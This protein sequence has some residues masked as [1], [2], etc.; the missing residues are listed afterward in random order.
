[1]AQIASSFNPLTQII[2]FTAL[3]RILLAT[4]LNLGN[5]EV[6]YF[7]YAV[8]PD[9]NH[10]DHPPLVG[11]F[12]RLTTLNLT[13]ISDLSMRLPAIFGAAINT[14][15]IAKCT[16]R[17][18]N[19]RAGIFASILYNASIYTSLISGLF[20]LPDS[21]QL[22]FW[23]VALH[24]MV[25]I[26]TAP[27]NANQNN[28]I[29][30]V[31][32]WIGLA[33]M[34]KV[35][36]IFLWLGFI[37]FIIFHRRSLLK[38]P[39]LY[40]GIAITLLLISPILY[41]NISNDFITW[42]FHSER[43]TVDEGIHF[44]S[45]LVTT[46]GQIL[47]SNPVQFVI[48]V[49]CLTAYAKRKKFIASDA[50]QLLLWC[51]VPIIFA[52]SLVSLFRSTLPHWSGPGFL[53]LMIIAA[54]YIDFSLNQYSKKAYRFLK[55]AVLIAS[56]VCVAGPLLIYFFPGTISDKAS[57]ETGLNDPTLDLH[58]WDE[59]L[60]A[61]DK[62]RKDDIANKRMSE[63]DPMVAHKWFPGGHIYYYVAYPLKMRFIGLGDLNDLHKFQWLNAIYGSIKPG[64]NAYYISPSNHFTDPK[65]RYSGKF[66]IIEK[67]ATMD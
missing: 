2:V 57:P 65:T 46:I 16:Q 24:E 20:I 52:T 36:G 35:H 60:P 26:V 53:G 3:I 12:I 9:W 45:F 34:C 10:F 50:V 29:L 32:I 62:I 55:A 44:K 63:G 15:L 25:K 22:M 33:M 66:D 47:Y 39:F 6:Y 5:D 56:F 23:L 67:A 59:L 37:G 42:K 41:W 4:F 51:S 21:V 28:R 43:V 38:N 19:E 13:W 48:Y 49:V 40:L 30:L 64:S 18:A 11:L 54:V 17:I 8:Q 14:W 61:F 58:G 27:E 1:M 7:T 31:G